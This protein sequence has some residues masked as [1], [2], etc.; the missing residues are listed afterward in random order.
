[1]EAD[2][3]HSR[4]VLRFIGRDVD[5]HLRRANPRRC[6]GTAGAL[7]PACIL[8][9]FPSATDD[10]EPAIGRPASELG[11]QLS[12]SL[13]SDAARTRRPVPSDRT[14]IAR[15]VATFGCRPPGRSVRNSV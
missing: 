5:E 13:A 3:V 10:G 11:V 14:I 8:G 1:V 9:A 4:D 6:S 7:P 2:S 12:S 15:I